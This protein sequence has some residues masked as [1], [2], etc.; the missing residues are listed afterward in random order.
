[1]SCQLHRHNLRRWFPLILSAVSL[2]APALKAESFTMTE[3][4][5]LLNRT[6]A[7]S[8]GYVEHQYRKVLTAPVEQRGELLFTPPDRFEKHVMQPVNESYALSGETLTITQANGKR[9]Q[10]SVRNQPLLRGLLMSFQAV[11]SGH[12]NDLQPFY[13]SELSGSAASWQLTLKPSDAQIKRYVAQ[14]IVSGQQGEPHQFAVSET[15]GDRVVT[16]IKH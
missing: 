5:K 1:M 7:S 9:R 15:S 16:E 4:A 12:L 2:H 6:E 14:I 11:V 8:V 10:I 3:L 13:D